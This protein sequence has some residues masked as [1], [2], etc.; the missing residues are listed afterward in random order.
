MNKLILILGVVA[1]S[2][3]VCFSCD[4]FCE[5]SDRVAIVVSF[6][7]SATR[8]LAPANVKIAGIINNEYDS[9]LT[10]YSKQSYSQVL[11]PVNPS[12]DTMSFSFERDDLPADTIKI[13]YTRYNGFVS[14][15]CGCV[16]HA[17]IDSVAINNIGINI[18]D[19]ETGGLKL[20][21][22]SII[23]FVVVNPKTNTVSYRQGVINAENIRIYY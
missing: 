5:E 7:S 11:L 8:E 19:V 2:A 14:P 4:E 10:L 1:L 22:S 9:T 16:T 17:K 23:N 13:L 15:E 20:T 21:G 12:A 6:Y 3:L 18:N